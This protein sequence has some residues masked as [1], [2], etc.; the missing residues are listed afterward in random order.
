MSVLFLRKTHISRT[1]KKFA[2]REYGDYLSKRKRDAKISPPVI[3]DF[4]SFGFMRRLVIHYASKCNAKINYRTKCIQWT[5]YNRIVKKYDA[6]ALLVKNSNDILTNEQAEI[7]E[8]ESYVEEQRTKLKVME[9]YLIVANKTGNVTP[10]MGYA[11]FRALGDAV[12]RR[13][14]ILILWKRICWAKEMHQRLV[15]Q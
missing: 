12:K 14:Y 15:N 8:I 10:D 4:R 13:K 2:R 9:D 1:E 7:T 6:L 11:T 3:D 5:C